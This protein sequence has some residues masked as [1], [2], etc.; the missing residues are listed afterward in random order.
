M[1][2]RHYF[3]LALFVFAI[4]GAFEALQNVR[5]DNSHKGEIN[6]ILSHLDIKPFVR[7][8]TNEN[9]KS[10]TLRKAHTQRAFNHSMRDLQQ[11][12]KN[13][14]NKKSSMDLADPTKKESKKDK[15]KKKAD[16]E[17]IVCEKG[18][19]ECEKKKKQLQAQ[20]E[21]EKKEKEDAEK[22]KE[23]LEIA[24]NNGLEDLLE[25]VSNETQPNTNQVTGPGAIPFNQET[26][27]SARYSRSCW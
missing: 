23:D 10:Q 11:L 17:E 5:V 19:K 24:E 7:S 16:T 1:S 20:K 14:N 15:G 13:Q 8:F 21:K 4:G 26:K 25:D 3:L 6:G 18:D 2:K 22:Q 27:S 12:A 9:T